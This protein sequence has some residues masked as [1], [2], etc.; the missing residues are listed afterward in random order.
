VGFRLC[1]SI[2]LAFLLI[3]PLATPL[4]AQDSHLVVITGLEG[5]AE[6]GDRFF[7]WASRL[8]DTVRTKFQLPAERVVFLSEKPERD[9]AKIN[10]RSTK[11][12]IDKALAGV[13]AGAKPTDVVFVVLFGHGSSDGGDARFNLPGPDLAAADF[14]KLLGRFQTQRIVFV[15]TTSSS[16]EF[17]KALSGPRRTILTAT[18]TGAERF[19]TQFGGFFVEA[20]ASD[21]ADGNKD[22]RVSVLEAFLYARGQVQRTF[23]KQ[24]FLQTEHALLDDDGDGEGIQDPDVLKPDGRVAATL[25]LGMA[26]ITSA[27]GAPITDAALKA[28]YEERLALERRISELGAIKSTMPPERYQAELEKLAT[29]L[30]LKNRDIKQ[31]EDKK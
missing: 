29:E 21:A 9:S 4:A 28:L 5:D 6:H 26:P 3:L 23:E 24:G 13:A 19:D 16:G 25:Y 30:A 18:R 11:E 1:H 22:R 10:G 14:A 31:R 15:N 27:S 8:V 2:G 20:I 17:V 7:D 12:A